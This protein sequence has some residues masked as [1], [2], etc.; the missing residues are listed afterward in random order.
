MMKFLKGIMFAAVLAACGL[1]PNLAHANSVELLDDSVVASNEEV[2]TI[3]SERSVSV[4][5]TA[6]NQYH[7]T[8]G[9]I[10]DDEVSHQFNASVT[11]G[12]W[13]AGAWYASNF[14]DTTDFGDELDLYGE[15]AG[16]GY[17]VGAQYF[18]LNGV[19]DIVNVYVAVSVGGELNLIAVPGATVTAAPSFKV[20]HYVSTDGSL[21]DGTIIRF[22]PNLTVNGDQKL[23]FG[24]D[25]EINYDNGAFGNPEGFNAFVNGSANYRLE[26][27]VTLSLL[28][29]HSTP[30]DGNAKP[31]NT[32][33]AAKIAKS[34]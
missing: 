16:D 19:G 18:F 33:F 13:T 15:Y 17:R 11:Q 26:N 22:A 27:G 8:D 25:P 4:D 28:A 32:S 1:V 29:R 23:F 14:N 9:N 5:Y 2:T 12:R 24:F 30:V 10:A 6:W 21:D 3:E 34:W 20:D 7:L 31:T